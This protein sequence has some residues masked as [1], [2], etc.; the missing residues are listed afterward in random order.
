MEP[1]SMS[2]GSF[3]LPPPTFLCLS[4]FKNMRMAT[5][6]R[7]MKP[8]MD[9]STYI[10]PN[11][12]IIWDV[13]WRFPSLMKYLNVLPFLDIENPPSFHL[14]K[15]VAL[16]PPTTSALYWSRSRSLHYYWG[17]GGL[18]L[19][20]AHPS[21]LGFVQERPYWTDL[22]MIAV[23]TMHWHLDTDQAIAGWVSRPM[24]GE[25]RQLIT[26]EPV[27]APITPNFPFGSSREI[28]G[29]YVKK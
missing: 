26:D 29:D 24:S 16:L 19:H 4:I 27:H 23:E 12:M 1:T 2:C 7:V 20:I 21:P 5:I 14:T 28:V 9:D 3:K 10:H 8:R 15:R 13:L 11:M 18:G 22:W 25:N 6:I 17:M